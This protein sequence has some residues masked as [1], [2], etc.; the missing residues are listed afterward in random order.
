MNNE[1]NQVI[2]ALKELIGFNKRKVRVLINL[3]GQKY[4]LN[5]INYDLAINTGL[6]YGIFQ[7]NQPIGLFKKASEYAR[8]VL[9]VCEQE[10]I[11]I[12]NIFSKD[13]PDSLKF[14]NSSYLFY[15]KGNLSCLNNPNRATIVGTRHPDEQ[16][17][18]FVY[19][20]GTLLTENNYTV[21]SGLAQGCDTQ[22]HLATLEHNGETVAFIPS[23][24][25][26]IAP[27]TNK[28]LANKIIKNN[29]L[30]I[31]EYS[32]LSTSNSSMY[33]T[34]DR[35]QAG[36]SN[37]VFASQFDEQSGTLQTLEFASQYNKPI[38]TLK[39]LTNNNEFN[40][41]N[42]LISK[43]IDCEILDWNEI[44][45]IIKNKKER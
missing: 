19:R 14:E 39:S 2:I 45:E 7:M 38:Y 25:R 36:A 12:V 8:K 31:T 43:R 5:Q 37:M 33:I 6:E 32:P 1:I 18:D 17:K 4:S 29:G 42:S 9:E 3:L 27:A 30:V 26:N 16:G 34:R 13:F 15:Y 22:A 21:I 41:L 28:D 10:N 24:L 40:G 11:K 44:V 23:N 35:L 20:L